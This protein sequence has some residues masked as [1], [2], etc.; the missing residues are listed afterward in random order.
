MSTAPPIAM[1]RLSIFMVVLGVALIL[2][3]PF[4]F[5]IWPAGFRW[6]HPHGHAPYERMIIAIYVSLGICMILAARDPLKNAI[7]ID[8]TILS[9][10]LHGGVMTYDSIAQDGE[11][12][13][14]L[15][16]VPLLFAVAALLWFYHPRRLTRR[17]EPST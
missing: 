5:E 16:D 9:S 15:G 17:E 12:M 14:L 3:I 1:R 10:I 13:H 7:L 6:G 2:T 8:F 11:L 4:A